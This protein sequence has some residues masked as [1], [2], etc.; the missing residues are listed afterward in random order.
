MTQELSCGNEIAAVDEKST[1]QRRSGVEYC[2][3]N[4]FLK[5]HSIL[6]DTTIYTLTQSSTAHYLHL[7]NHN[8]KNRLAPT[9][10]PHIDNLTTEYKLTEN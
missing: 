8:S 2:Q 1:S 10:L 5:L 4:I 3:F 7:G 6:P 9:L